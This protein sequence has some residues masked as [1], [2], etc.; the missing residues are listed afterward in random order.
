MQQHLMAAGLLSREE[1]S[2]V[3]YLVSWKELPLD[4]ATWEAE[5]VRRLH[6]SCMLPV[7]IGQPASERLQPGSAR[8][9]AACGL[10]TELLSQVSFCFRCLVGFWPQDLR[11]FAAE[12]AAYY[13]SQTPITADA[14]A[15]KSLLKQQ[16]QEQGASVP[17]ALNG[18]TPAGDAPATATTAA[19]DERGDGD[20]GGGGTAAGQQRGEGSR[21]W[22]STPPFVKGGELHPY[23]LEGL[24]WLYHKAHVK[25]N[26]I[27]ADEMG[28]GKT[29]QAIAYLGA[30]WQVRAFP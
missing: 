22:D 16:Q 28:L 18:A 9:H 11:D 27:L 2:G 17:S 20:D 7:R 14:A 12:I 3:E 19:A 13:T 21:K 10:W 6:E 30:L 25:D 26:V 15:R 8:P 5:E 29:I 23:Q 24:N 1:R 4:Q